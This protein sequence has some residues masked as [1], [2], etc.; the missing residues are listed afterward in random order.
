MKYLSDKGLDYLIQKTVAGLKKLEKSIESTENATTAAQ[1]AVSAA[2]AADNAAQVAAEATAAAEQSTKECSELVAEVTKKLENGEFTPVKNVDYFTPEEKQE[3]VNDVLA[4]L[5]RDITVTSWKAV[6]EVVRAGKAAEVFAIG[7]QIECQHGKY[8]TLVWDVIGIDH[9]TPANSEFKHSLTIQLHDCIG[10][11]TFQFD[12]AEPTNPD[13]N[14]K[15]SGS[16]NWLE[17]GI[18]QWLNSD[19]DAGTWWEAKTD[20]DVKPSYASSTAGF[21]KGL[22]AEFL[23]TVGE[24]SKITARNTV[25]DG[26]DSDTSTE[27]FFLLSMTEVYGGLNNNIAEGV[28]YP[29]Y[30]DNSVLS[31]AGAGNDAN[32]IKYRNGAAQYWWL[33]SPRTS[34]SFGVCYASPTGHIH[35]HLARYSY[36][37][38]PAC[39]IY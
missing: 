8:G 13:S 25:T 23:S 24:V 19:G 18:R 2:K 6:Q 37:V 30:A 16:N 36:G 27:K 11:A 3:M 39:C 28:A 38:A 21:L 15:S 9:D 22:D 12:A 7:D 4:S 10:A 5:P 17:S 34:F 29:Y 33:R 1:I 31:A 26:G 20:Y 35:N 32:R 14:R